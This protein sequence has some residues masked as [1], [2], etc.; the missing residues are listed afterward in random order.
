[1]KTFNEISKL[2]DNFETGEKFFKSVEEIDFDLENI[3]NKE[4]FV[5]FVVGEYC[6]KN[7][8]KEDML[9]FFLHYYLDE[10]NSSKSISCLS[11]LLL[12]CPSANLNL[13]KEVENKINR[14]EKSY[15]SQ[16]E[17]IP[18]EIK[19]YILEEL[20][21]NL[22]DGFIMQSMIMKLE[23]DLQVSDT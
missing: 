11:T 18:V 13:Y 17:L 23:K 3:E 20:K 19:E 1:M 4:F 7:P 14:F 6:A 21:E 10:E 22:D 5:S 9:K 12:Q 2:L 8:V 16:F 15:L